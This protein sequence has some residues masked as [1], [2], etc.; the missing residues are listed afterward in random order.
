MSTIS[1]GPAI[2]CNFEKLDNASPEVVFDGTPVKFMVAPSSKYPHLIK[3]YETTWPIGNLAG[4]KNVAFPAGDSVYSRI[5]V[6][7]ATGGNN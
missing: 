1:Y 3:T 2:A 4:V 5:A 6:W 7:F